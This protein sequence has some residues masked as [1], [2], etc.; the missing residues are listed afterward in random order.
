MKIVSVLVFGAA[1]VGSWMMTRNQAPIPE[2]VH[3]G[4]QDDLKRII[5]EYVQKQLPESKNLRF[6]R[7]WTEA[8]K[9]NKVKAVFSYSFEDASRGEDAL[10]HIEGSAILNKVSETPETV[11][12]SM[13]ELQVE[14]STVDFQEPIH[15]TSTASP[16]GHNSAVITPPPSEPPTETH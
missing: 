11:T 8:L 7:F 14:D 5:T 4:I 1:L 13:D 6:Q 3:L 12:W 15:I 2:S 10:L 16:E 9:K